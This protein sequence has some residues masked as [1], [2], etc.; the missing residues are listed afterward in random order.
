[1]S[2]RPY[3]ETKHILWNLLYSYFSFSS[4]FALSLY[5]YIDIYR[6][7]SVHTNPLSLTVH[8]GL[9]ETTSP[10]KVLNQLTSGLTSIEPADVKVPACY[11]SLPQTFFFP[12]GTFSSKTHSFKVTDD[13]TSPHIP[14]PPLPRLSCV[15]CAHR[16]NSATE[17]GGDLTSNMI[18]H[19]EPPQPGYWSGC[20]PMC[21]VK[22]LSGAVPTDIA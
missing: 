7:W 10:F 3:I 12:S 13:D 17:W 6:D 5:I 22:D 8:V 4:L 2:R 20:S 11:I 16:V 19:R 18:K 15:L 14:L 1:M 21:D 9:E